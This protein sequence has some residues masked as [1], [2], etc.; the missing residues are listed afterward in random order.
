LGVEESAF[1]VLNGFF[2]EF[3]TPFTLGGHNFFNSNPFFMIFNV[4]DAPKGRL[5]VFFGHQKQ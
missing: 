4:L 1:I 3:L 2:K 5:Q